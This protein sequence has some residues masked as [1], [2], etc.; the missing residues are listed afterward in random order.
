MEI[1]KIK[2]ELNNTKN[3][4][5]TLQDLTLKIAQNNALKAMEYEAFK[6]D[7]LASVVNSLVKDGILEPMKV[8]HDKRLHKLPLKYRI[9]KTSN[10]P[11]MP[12]EYLDDIKW[13][14]SKLK[15]NRDIY[16]DPTL[17]GKYREQIKVVDK[18]IK[19]IENGKIESKEII[20][21]NERS[22]ELFTDEKLLSGQGKNKK[23]KTESKEGYKFQGL[24][25]LLG[26]NPI[27][28]LCA[29]HYEPLLIFASS[30]FYSK[31]SRTILII[32]NLDT[33]WTFQRAIF[34]DN[35]FSDIDMLI[36]GAG[37]K[38]TGGFNTHAEFGINENDKI[39]YYGDIDSAGLG[40]YLKIKDGN[41]SLRIELFTEVY[42]TLLNCTLTRVK[43]DNRGD[44]QSMMEDK[45]LK[46][47]LNEFENP[48]HK[49]IIKT[50]I[51]E[52]RYIPQ[53]ALNY[54]MIKE[55]WSIVNG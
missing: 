50:L 53:E 47:I 9:N 28:L 51:K 35:I 3:N 13:F 23:S 7:E 39:L 48:E 26:L 55:R 11:P 52:E 33:F 20:G 44:K 2:A 41:E 54:A 6:Y 10:I 45:E 25:K 27:D 17:Y 1:T 4:T 36:Y 46:R 31:I 14:H 22:Y 16:K 32:E 5:V 8:G 37:N 30:S 29:K 34:R 18:F 15:G 40:F 24:L 19:D 43:L 21:I 38:I 49:E 42:E 12:K